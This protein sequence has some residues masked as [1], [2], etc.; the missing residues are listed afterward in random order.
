MYSAEV[1]VQ[2][3]IAHTQLTHSHTCTFVHQMRVNENEGAKEIHTAH[4]CYK[5]QLI[6]VIGN[7]KP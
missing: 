7:K 3:K 4:T 1:P 2:K 5:L 6:I